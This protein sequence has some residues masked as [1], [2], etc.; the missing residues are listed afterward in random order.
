M[1]FWRLSDPLVLA[2]GSSARRALLEAAAIPLEIIKPD[3]DE[4]ALAAPLVAAGQ[5]PKGIAQALARAKA[6]AVSASY[7]DR[8]VLAADQTLDLAGQLGMK[9]PDLASARTQLRALRG[10]THQLHSAAVLARA[11]AVLW[12]G[13]Q[14]ANLTMRAF[15]DAFLEAYL[16]AMG[17]RV[18]TTVGGYELEAL[19][20]H[21]FAN[22]EGDHATILGLP[23]HPVLAALRD[24]G[25]LLG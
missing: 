7:P 24:N 13:S 22:V 25:A 8:L 12:Q 3:L 18:L 5:S 20:V 9:A 11:G 6:L 23:L 15:S 16:A 21:L 17:E 14:S 10:T 2:S 19:G 4:A 1:S